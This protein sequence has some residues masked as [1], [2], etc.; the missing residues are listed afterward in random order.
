MR[1]RLAA[2][3][4]QASGLTVVV[5]MTLSHLIND[6]FI[7][8][9]TPLLP[10]IRSQY[11]VTIARTAVLVA[12]LSIVG[13][14]IQPLVGIVGDRIDRRLL[15][16]LAPIL[17]ALGMSLIGYAPNLAMLGVLIAIAGV[18]SAI[19]HPSGA[20]YVAMGAR[21]NER[22]LW[23]S[24]FSAGGTVGLALGPLCAYALGLRGLPF[25]LPLG[26]AMGVAS[27]AFV[28]SSQGSHGG[29]TNLAALAVI[30]RGPIRPLW[31]MSVL[32]SLATVAYMSLLGFVLTADGYA[33]H[34]GPSLAVLNFASAIGGLVGGRLSDS[35]GRIVVLRSSVLVTI[36]LF[37]GL[38]FSHPG[39]WWYY[40][41]TALVGA[42][43][44]A[45]I[46]VAVVT[47]QEYAPKH[48]ATASA[49]MMGFAWGTSGVLFLG[50]G[51]LAD[52]IG[53][54]LAMVVAIAALLPALFLTLRLP[55][56]TPIQAAAA[57]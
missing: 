24:I 5:L 18:G 43:V 11:G 46:P 15:V 2:P 34:I 8:L 30:W 12:I 42:L 39:Q 41:L 26:L 17:A 37:V 32:R 28:P 53:P 21:A 52:S 49:M 25:L 19:F 13:S 48:I 1:L 44:N 4:L 7:S 36:P 27:F 51:R 22:G 50:V 3:V 14:M 38:V 45:N 35:L 56:P 6:T 16:G 33:A 40:P 10:A 23:A 47:A 31:A 9:L 57:S 29:G 20:A 55:E 54:R